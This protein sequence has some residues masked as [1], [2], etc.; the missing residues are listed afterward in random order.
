MADGSPPRDPT[1]LIA[2]TAVQDKAA[3][4]LFDQWKLTQ[5][6]RLADERHPEVFGIAL[7]LTVF[8]PERV[9]APYEHKPLSIACIQEGLVSL[10][11]APS[12]PDAFLAGVLS[13]AHLILRFDLVGPEGR[14]DP[15]TGVPLA[16]W[17]ERN[18]SERPLPPIAAA[19]PHTCIN[20]FTLS[21]LKR[22]VPSGASQADHASREIAA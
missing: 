14:W 4:R 20:A 13:K 2:V 8:L 12:E 1:E 19:W 17:F 21:L 10:S 15:I 18:G 22:L 5:A 7:R 11:E 6:L 9:L 16:E 3:R